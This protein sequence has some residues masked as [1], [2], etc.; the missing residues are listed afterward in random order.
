MSFLNELNKII[1]E[2]A[3]I[4]FLDLPLN[5]KARLDFKY[6]CGT[7]GYTTFNNLNYQTV[8]T[9]DSKEKYIGEFLV[10][11]YN[12]ESEIVKF[13][14]DL[15]NLESEN[16]FLAV[17]C[18]ENNSVA[19][20]LIFKAEEFKKFR[21]LPSIFKDLKDEKAFGVKLGGLDNTKLKQYSFGYVLKNLV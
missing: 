14:Q 8:K 21:L 7:T 19:D 5:Q 6:L 17:V 11:G 20:I 3:E 10:I 16:H 18:Y 9:A 13:P 4:G 15:L 2:N 1:S 12:V